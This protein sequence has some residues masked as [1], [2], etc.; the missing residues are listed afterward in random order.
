MRCTCHTADTGSHKAG[1]GSGAVMESPVEVVL[2]FEG[3]PGRASA[4]AQAVAADDPE[5]FELQQQD[6][7]LR[8]V[9]QGTQL[10]T[11]RR[12]VD[13]LLACLAAAEAGLVAL[14]G[15]EDAADDA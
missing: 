4:L 15:H 2:R 14:D 1:P 9:V 5:T 13:D 11:V 12:S 3:E 7:S 6:G 8:L 10:A